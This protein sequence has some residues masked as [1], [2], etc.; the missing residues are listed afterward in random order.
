M[1]DR[2]DHCCWRSWCVRR[3]PS[4]PWQ[5]LARRLAACQNSA[6]PCVL[7]LDVPHDPA[8][9]DL[10]LEALLRHARPTPNTRWEAD[11]ERTLFA[12]RASR[13]RRYVVI[14]AA[15]TGLAGVIA[16]A[17]LAGAGPL[18]SH[19]GSGAQAGA[20]CTTLYDTRVQPVGELVRTAGGSV[21]VRTTH[22]PVTHQHTACR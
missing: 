6:G 19:G 2:P 8:N 3:S 1:G 11:L 18:A 14:G 21:V 13:A 16:V 20:H 7:E 5:Q 4:A 12:R 17:S 22:K 15:A 10:E 9:D